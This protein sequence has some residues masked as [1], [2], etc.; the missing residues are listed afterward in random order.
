MAYKIGTV[1]PT[2]FWWCYNILNPDQYGYIIA[3][4]MD[5]HCAKNYQTLDPQKEMYIFAP[6]KIKC[7][8]ILYVNIFFVLFRY[9]TFPLWPILDLSWNSLSS[10]NY[11]H[12]SLSSG[13]YLHNSLSLGNHLRN[14]LLS[15]NYLHNSLSLGNHLH[16]SLN[17]G[18]YLHNSVLSGN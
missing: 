17:S 8:H 16:Y 2:F 14:S 10:G 15:G 3:V 13:N 1:L 11:L 5:L 9:G 6:S 4:W 12:N 18:N 7:L